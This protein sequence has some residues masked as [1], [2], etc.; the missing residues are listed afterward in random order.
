MPCRC[1][2]RPFL[3]QNSASCHHPKFSNASPLSQEP[4]LVVVL[5]IEYFWDFYFSNIYIASYISFLV[6]NA[7]WH[8]LSGRQIRVTKDP[9]VKSEYWEPLSVL[10]HVVGHSAEWQ[11]FLRGCGIQG[12]A[13]VMPASAMA[14]MACN[15]RNCDFFVIVYIDVSSWVAMSI[16]PP[17][18]QFVK[19]S[20]ICGC[21]LD[22]CIF[23]ITEW[24]VVI[25]LRSSA[26]RSN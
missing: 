10:Y 16:Q 4:C 24:I 21:R 26:L 25:I 17:W 11:Q 19:K 22:M 14:C 12:L 1:L 15:W 8:D 6:G 18:G 13:S 2:A 7:C 5:R 9:V 3:T 20:E 23:Y